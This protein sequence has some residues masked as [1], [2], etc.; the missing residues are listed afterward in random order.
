MPGA[1]ERAYVYARSCGMLEKSFIGKKISLLSGLSRLSELDR[2]IFP[3]GGRE[4]P[5]RELLRDLEERISGR[6]VGQIIMILSSFRKP[7]ELM[8]RLLRAYEYADLKSALN[9]LSGGEKRRPAFTDLGPFQTLNFAAWPDFP[10]V[11]RGTEFEFLLKR[12]LKKLDPAESIL[13]ETELD[14]IYY[15]SLWKALYALAPRDRVCAEKLLAEELSL[16]NVLWALR[17]RTYYEMPAEEARKHLMEGGAGKI[18][19]RSLPSLSAD[20]EASLGFAL[21]NRR[22]WEGWNREKFLNPVEGNGSWRADPRYFQNAASDYLYR[23]ARR[24]FHRN[25]FSLDAVFCF[26]KL[27]QFEEDVL[28]SVAEGL[29]L[30]MSG[31][32]V[33][34]LLGVRR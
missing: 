6:A 23:L 13:I 17:L 18:R 19:R 5:E 16:R 3:R 30:G 20:A 21:D 31:G 7:P 29:G 33:F 32:D 8:I 10:A 28:T 9:A 26:I 27:K 25:P 2:L 11:I 34:P 14:R 22:D 4:L 12:D 1:G 15:A 24:S